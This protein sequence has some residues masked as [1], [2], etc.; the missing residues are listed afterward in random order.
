MKSVLP[1]VSLRS[2]MAIV[3]GMGGVSMIL[4]RAYAGEVWAQGI[5]MALAYLATMFAFYA[6][7]FATAFVV[8]ASTPRTELPSSPFAGEA[9]PDQIMV[10]IDSFPK[11]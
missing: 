3:A 11:N 7:T 4:S 1:R 9:P 2:Y 8:A 5:T 10:P 6:V